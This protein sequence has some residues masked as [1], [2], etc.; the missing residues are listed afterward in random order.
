[1][2][3]NFQLVSVLFVAIDKNYSSDFFYVLH[4]NL[5]KGEDTL[6]VRVYDDDIGDKDKIGS[7]KISLKK[8]REAGG[9]L[10]EWVKL[11]AL[12]GLRSHGE[13]HLILKLS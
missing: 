5:K 7:A 11:P 9:Q 4:S 10:D 8:V 13:I 1:M 2:E 12:M 6:H 3:W